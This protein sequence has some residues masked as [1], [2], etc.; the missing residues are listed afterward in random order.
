MLKEHLTQDHENASRRLTTIERH[1]DWLV[2]EVLGQPPARLLDL[3]CGPGLY[4]QRLAARGYTCTGID[5]SPASIA[6]ARQQAAQAGLVIDYHEAD[7]RSADFGPAASFDCV[8]LIFG[9]LNVFKPADARTILRKAWAALKPGGRLVLEPATEEHVRSIGREPLEW[10]ASQSGLFGDRPHIMLSESFWDEA[11]RAATTRY[12]RID[13]ENGEVVR[14]ASS[15]QAY[16]QADYGALLAEC[17][18]H[19][20]RF[21]PGLAAQPGDPPGMFWGLVAEK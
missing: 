11:A 18:F 21:W 10:W 7:L 5:F 19:S 12:Y 4:L 17:G 16:S 2:R 13:T 9:E 14:Y 20:P 3:G 8:M 1:V 15:Q 6:H